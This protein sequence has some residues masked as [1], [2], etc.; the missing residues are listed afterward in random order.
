MGWFVAATA[1]GF[2][3][4]EGLE[5]SCKCEEE[6]RRGNKN[7]QIEVS[8][9]SVAKEVS[10][11]ACSFLHRNLKYDKFSPSLKIR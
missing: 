10:G 4:A 9:A 6:Q 5:R 3:Q 2:V 7:T 1:C 11:H 8:Q